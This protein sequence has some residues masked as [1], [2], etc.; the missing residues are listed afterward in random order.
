V[1]VVAPGGDIGTHTQEEVDYARSLGKNV[2]T[3]DPLALA[4]R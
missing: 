4:T 3:V 2:R 1:V